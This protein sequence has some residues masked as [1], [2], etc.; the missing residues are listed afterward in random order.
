VSLASQL[1]GAI[2]GFGLLAKQ[3]HPAVLAPLS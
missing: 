1:G 2:D 3:Q